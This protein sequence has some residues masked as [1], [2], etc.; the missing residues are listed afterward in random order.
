[1]KL[2]SNHTAVAE[3]RKMTGGS[4]VSSFKNIWNT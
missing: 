3:N 4:W 1:M 2:I